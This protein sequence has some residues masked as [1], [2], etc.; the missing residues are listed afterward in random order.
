MLQC[1]G[2][3]VVNETL[4]YSP[5]TPSCVDCPLNGQPKVFGDGPLEAEILVIG[6]SPGGTEEDE[7]APFVGASGQIVNTAIRKGGES[8][9]TVRVENVYQ[10]K[11]RWPSAKA[12]QAA[13]LC[14]GTLSQ[15]IAAMPNLR[16]IVV[17][18]EPALQYTSGFAQSQVAIKEY[19]KATK[20]HAR[21]VISYE[22]KVIKYNAKLASYQELCRVSSEAG[23]P[24][25][26]KP[27]KSP[28][29]PP[30]FT[31]G[32]R[33]DPVGFSGIY[34]LRGS[35][36]FLPGHSSVRLFG[37][38]HPA[39]TLPRR[40]PRLLPLVLSD[41]KKAFEFHQG[42]RVVPP[43]GYF[44]PKT[45]EEIFKWFEAAPLMGY[46]GLR[47]PVA[48]D[49]E[50]SRK[51]GQLMCIG[52][53]MEKDRYMLVPAH[54]AD[55]LQQWFDDPRL[56]WGGHF[57]VGYDERKLASIGL[58]VR[59]EWDTLYGFHL[60]F[61]ELG[62]PRDE[63]SQ[64]I[65]QPGTKTQTQA[66]G[67]DL[68][69]VQSVLTNFPYHKGVVTH[70]IDA[71]D[72]S[73]TDLWDY[74]IKDVA[75]TLYAWLELDSEIRRRWPKD[76]GKLGFQLLV[77]DMDDCRMATSMSLQGVPI[78]ESMRLEREWQW[79]EK[80]AKI[81]ARAVELEGGDFNIGSTH[82]LAKA[83]AKYG[84]E[85]QWNPETKK[86]KLNGQIIEKLMRQY[87]SNPLLGLARE[88]RDSE[89]EL[90]GYAALQPD[91][92]NLAHP[93]WKVHGTV[94][95]RWSSSPNFQNLTHKQR[96]VIG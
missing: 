38:I 91:E 6:E 9:D 64:E 42:K 31:L 46:R 48:F 53:G 77:S 21:K 68:G 95:P 15:T 1:D 4:P 50:W 70:E 83:L 90:T 55:A 32:G 82:H 75:A 78:R 87:P 34:D 16:T 35:L 12:K 29:G 62:S 13:K 81:K 39:V 2:V 76:H 69:F 43:V 89:K 7:G 84:I 10:C 66:T 45:R 61:A 73:Q 23:K 94:G 41:L 14:G 37:S 22:K 30:T 60:V 79:I 49:I 67:Y 19:D 88:W 63:T 44:V 85:V 27:P 72:V 80:Q 26:R 17:L 33:P 57:A 18:G 40:Q 47:R 25:K 56:A 54:L 86:P 8:R 74:C 92:K 93:N 52:V 51:Q 24:T 96:E 59:C 65:D 71:G 58:H 36:L 11:A 3:L 5:R 20:K 28:E